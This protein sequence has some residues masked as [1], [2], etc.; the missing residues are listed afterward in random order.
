MIKK[1]PPRLSFVVPLAAEAASGNWGRSCQLLEMGLRSLL[2]LPLDKADIKVVGHD[3]PSACSLINDRRVQFF[4][5]DFE[6]PDSALKGEDLIQAKA[7]DKGKKVELGTKI[8]HASEAEWVMFCDADDLVSRK[9]P[10]VCNFETADAVVLDTGWRWRYG[11]KVLTRCRNF[12]R[13]CGTSMLIRLTQRNFPCWLGGGCNPVA[14]LGHNA[15]AEALQK[16]GAVVQILKRPLA[17]YVVENGCNYYYHS[18]TAAFGD[19]LQNVLRGF[20][21]RINTCRISDALS[22]EFSLPL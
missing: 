11:T 4:P 21:N 12:H 19:L 3:F 16:A 2:A 18:Q 5:V 6:P 7:K 10:E 17:V 8:A 22:S 13:V 1:H 9:L 14:E 15:R 20:K